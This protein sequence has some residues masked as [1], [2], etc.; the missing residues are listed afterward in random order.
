MA[1]EQQSDM[2]CKLQRRYFSNCVKNRWCVSAEVEYI[3]AGSRE[4]NQK[5]AGNGQVRDKG[6]FG[7]GGIGKEVAGFWIYSKGKTN[8]C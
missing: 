6:R 7:K 2:I 3:K 4:T 1:F 8:V 5:A